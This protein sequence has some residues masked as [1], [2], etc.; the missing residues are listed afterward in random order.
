M[1]LMVRPE[2]GRRR[3]RGKKKKRWQW[4]DQLNSDCHDHVHIEGDCAPTSVRERA[5]AAEIRQCC[6][7]PKAASSGEA[8]RSLRERTQFTS[9]YRPLGTVRR[10]EFNYF[11]GRCHRDLSRCY[12]RLFPDALA[13][14]GTP[15]RTAKD[16][17]IRTALPRRRRWA[18]AR[19]RNGLRSRT[20]LP[21]SSILM[22][23]VVPLALV[24]Q[25]VG[26]CH[27]GH[28]LSAVVRRQCCG[29][30]RV[31]LLKHFHSNK[32]ENEDIG[33]WFTQDVG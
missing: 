18:L 6:A 11:R 3:A 30:P 19:K 7:A 29:A 24:A 4:P 20:I 14:L 16:A 2:R 9:P 32:G 15:T 33:F 27:A 21:Q 8:G 13:W 1:K 12:R 10:N 26:C 5:E 23:G 28:A 22:T 17:R 25:L 31:N